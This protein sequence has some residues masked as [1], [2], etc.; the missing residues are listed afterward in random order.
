MNPVCFDCA[1]EMR[2]TRNAQTVRKS[3]DDRREFSGD[4]FRCEVCGSQVVIGFGRAV[5]LTPDQQLDPGALV[6][7][8]PV[9]AGVR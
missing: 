8:E 7:A 5:T 2:C 3:A 4:R 6:L 9:P 1:V